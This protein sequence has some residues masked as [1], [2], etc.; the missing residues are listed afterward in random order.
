MALKC[1]CILFVKFVSYSLLCYYNCKYAIIQHV[2][3]QFVLFIMFSRSWWPIVSHECVLIN[4]SSFFS[5]ASI[6][7][8]FFTCVLNLWT[9]GRLMRRK[10]PP[11]DAFYSAER[12][13]A[14]FLV[15]RFSYC[16]TTELSWDHVARLCITLFFT[17]SPLIQLSLTCPDM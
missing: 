15:A 13:S 14:V 6:C 9:T 16:V 12:L 2:F 17:I 4:C 10:R 11:P 5:F 7:L 8:F 3:S 1:S